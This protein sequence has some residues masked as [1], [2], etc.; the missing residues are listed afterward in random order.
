LKEEKIMFNRLKKLAR[1][2][3]T[4]AMLAAA[5][6]AGG[7]ISNMAVHTAWA[8][9]FL[10]SYPFAGVNAAPS[11]DFLNPP[12]SINPVVQGGK[13]GSTKSVSTI[14]EALGAVAYGSL[15]TATTY[16]ASTDVYVTSIFIPYDMTVTNI[17]VL[18]GGTVTTN[19][20]IASLY[21]GAGKLIA[22]STTA[23]TATSG[24][25]TFQTLALVT[26]TAIQGPATYYIGLSANGTTDNARLIAASTYVGNNT[27][28]VTG[29]VFGTLTNLSALPTTFNANVGPIAYLN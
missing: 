14:G 18:A 25:N 2:T 22:N 7:A 16:A 11:I 29:Q 26:A 3:A 4:Y 1:T 9:Q 28:L 20:I 8:Q 27:L 15:G 10:W 6:M 12:I 17:N 21:N 24:A 5:G 19:T 13:I 23:G